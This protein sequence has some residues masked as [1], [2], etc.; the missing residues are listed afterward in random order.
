MRI[1]NPYYITLRYETASSLSNTVTSYFSQQYCFQTRYL[2]LCQAIGSNFII[3]SR[4]TNF[5]SC[6][7][8]SPPGGAKTP[9]PVGGLLLQG[10]QIQFFA[11]LIV[12]ALKAAPLLHHI[13]HII[14]LICTIAFGTIYHR[15]SY[16]EHHPA[17]MVG[18]NVP[19]IGL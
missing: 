7:K 12:K 17:M 3:H 11:P 16:H 18:Y 5:L 13:R 19:D 9:H 8:H 10:L 15:S 2:F 1:N 4:T 14:H 6:H